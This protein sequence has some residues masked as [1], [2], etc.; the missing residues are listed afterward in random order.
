[1]MWRGTLYST[2]LHGSI[3]VALFAS[4]P[5][6]PDIFKRTP[7]SETGT[8]ELPIPIEVV[9]ADAVDLRQDVIAP[10]PPRRPAKQRQAG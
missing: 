2:L 6:L 5:I 10:A 3:A 8:S 9:S 4:L 1:M 7:D